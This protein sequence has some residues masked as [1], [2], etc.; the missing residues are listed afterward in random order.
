MTAPVNLFDQ[1]IGRL[2]DVLCAI[3]LLGWDART[4]M[5]AGAGEMRGAQVATLTGVARGIA[6]GQAMRDAIAVELDHLEDRPESA[7]RR[8]VAGYPGSY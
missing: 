4:Q 8:R 3:N 2:N 5:P 7:L 1:E 6:T